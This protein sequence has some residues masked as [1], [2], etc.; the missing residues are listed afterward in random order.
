MTTGSGHE[1]AGAAESN[2]IPAEYPSSRREEQQDIGAEP[3]TE[4]KTGAERAPEAIIPCAGLSSRMGTWKPLLPYRGKPLVEH[5]V[6][7]ALTVCS[8]IILVTGYRGE[9]LEALF[10]QN[11]RVVCS[12]N[13]DYRLGM[14]SSIRT[15]AAS[16]TAD[17]FFVAMGDM[18]EIPPRLYRLL[19][20]EH[21]CDVV[22]PRYR[23]IPAHPVL[24]AAEAAGYIL[25]LPDD[26]DMGRVLRAFELREIEVDEPGSI[27]DIDTAEEYRGGEY[28][29]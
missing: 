13:R 25:S 24:F 20:S 1:T 2:R 11:P 19:L 27:R 6:A 26:A 4:P 10:E 17:R 12:L 28:T 14:F 16:V 3:E 23:S 18:P 7:N 22:R 9:E 5:A 15:G 21:N 29:T 8:R